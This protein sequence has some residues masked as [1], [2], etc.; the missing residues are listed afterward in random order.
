MAT[1]A[2]DTAL[3]LV[4][5]QRGLAASEGD[6]NNPDAERQASLLLEAWRAA[7]APRVHVQHLSV[8]PRSPLRPELPGA[9]LH[10]AVTPRADEPLFQKR[11][12]SPFAA[13]TLEAHLRALGVRRLVVAG[14][15]TEHCVSSAC[16]AASDLGFEVTI[17]EDAAACFGRTSYDGRYHPPEEIHRVALVAL[18]EEFATIRTVS[19]VLAELEAARVSPP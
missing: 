16:R 10:D 19:E 18:H 8:R 5:I 1:N 13:S 12:A 14:L 17:A 3:L 11:V 7:G 6:R 2:A 9:A 4:D 15:T